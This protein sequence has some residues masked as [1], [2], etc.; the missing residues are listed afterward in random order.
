VFGGI[1][2][3]FF[4]G[5]P[6]LTPGTLPSY[7]ADGTTGEIEFVPWYVIVLGLTVGA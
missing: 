3:P 1:I 7:L 2:D 6:T 5:G 4:G